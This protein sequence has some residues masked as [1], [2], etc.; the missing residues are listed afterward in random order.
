MAK[1]GNVRRSNGGN[2]KIVNTDKSK[3]KKRKK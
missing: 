1:K 2:R 3:C